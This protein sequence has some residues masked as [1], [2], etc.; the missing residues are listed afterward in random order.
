MVVMRTPVVGGNFKCNGTQKFIQEHSEVLKQMKNNG[1]EVFVAPTALSLLQ[2]KD[3]LKDSHIQVAA[4]NIY[5]EKI[6]AF[7]GELATELIVDA[8]IKVVLVGHSERRRI[9]GETNEQSAKKAAKALGDNLQV[10]FC[11]GETLEERNNHQVDEV[12]FAQLEALRQQ[13]KEEQWKNVIIAYEPVWSIGTGVVASPQQAQEVHEHL[14][15]WLKEKVS[16]K[17]ADE[18]RIQYGGSVNAKNC[19]ELSK[20][21]DIDGFLVGGASLKAEFLDIVKIIG[22]VKKE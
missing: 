9:M 22:D 3:N 21:K 16:Q 18:T 8:G 2:L 19:A 4:Q 11:I 1:V 20:C 10:V 12:N 17:V 7:T 6:G 14:R 13:I 15:G 5:Y